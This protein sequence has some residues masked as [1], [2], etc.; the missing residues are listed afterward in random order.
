MSTKEGRNFT[1]APEEYSAPPYAELQPWFVRPSTTLLSPHPIY[2]V[3]SIVSKNHT[4]KY[5]IGYARTSPYC[6]DHVPTNETLEMRGKY[7]CYFN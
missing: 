1:S 7:Q 4:L 3:F 6:T 5:S 2:S